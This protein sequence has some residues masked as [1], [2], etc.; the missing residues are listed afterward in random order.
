MAAL[1]K[2]KRQKKSRGIDNQP[3]T[4]FE[5][6]PNDIVLEMIDYLDEKNIRRA[7]HR[8]NQR[9]SQLI[10]HYSGRSMTLSFFLT[11][12]PKIE[13]HCH[14]LIV[15]NKHRIRSLKFNH[16]DRLQTVLSRCTLDESFTRLQSIS[17]YENNVK[18]LLTLLHKLPQLPRLEALQIKSDLSV[19]QK[20]ALSDIYSIAFRCSLL[21][22]LNIENSSNKIG[23]QTFG[24]IN[25]SI[26]QSNIE[27]LKCL[28]SIQ[29]QQLQFLLEKTPKLRRLQVS[30]VQSDPNKIMELF[31]V[32]GLNQLSTLSI[33]CDYR[34]FD[35]LASRKII[36]GVGATTKS[37]KLVFRL[38]NF[39]R[40]A[41]EWNKLFNENLPHA[42]KFNITL[43]YDCGDLFGLGNG[44]RKFSMNLLKLSRW[45]KEPWNITFDAHMLHECA[46][47][48][49]LSK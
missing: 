38:R 34:R 21:I 42:E 41:T 25:I 36:A 44:F 31:M 39:I 48:F 46:V 23:A 37:L 30:Q 43:R 29:L 13:Q 20:D 27:V 3:Y 47:V 33:D 7:F 26:E 45:D 49:E 19:L 17:L 5:K 9:F 40:D 10:D 35:L 16:V 4:Q 12:S 1:P 6:L 24:K 8:L 2:T 32:P 18:D 22:Y 15:P 28:H 11:D 14:E